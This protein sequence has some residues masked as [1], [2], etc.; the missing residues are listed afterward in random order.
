M[1]KQKKGNATQS[2]QLSVGQPTALLPL[3]DQITVIPGPCNSATSETSQRTL[4]QV[5]RLTVQAK[6]PH[7][8]CGGHRYYAYWYER[9][10]PTTSV[11]ATL[12]QP[13]QNQRTDSISAVCSGT[14]SKELSQ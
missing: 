2:P 6:H 14:R 12:H 9:N 4:K 13:S 10:T 7:N 1:P 8:L 11:V 3:Y 5:L